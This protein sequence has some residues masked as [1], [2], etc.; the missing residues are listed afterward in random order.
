MDTIRW[1][2]RYI[3]PYRGRWIFASV[4]TIIVAL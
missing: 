4:L 2:A 3:R 1:L